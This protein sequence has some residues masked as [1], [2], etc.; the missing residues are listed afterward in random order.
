[1]L[2]LALIGVFWWLGWLGT[3]LSRAGGRQEKGRP[4]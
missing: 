3:G 2:G 4:G 1:V